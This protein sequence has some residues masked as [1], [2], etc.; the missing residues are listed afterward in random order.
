M[1]AGKTY[2][3]PR[4]QPNR[5]MRAESPPSDTAGPSRVCRPPNTAFRHR[6][7]SIRV[8]ADRH[9]P[10]ASTQTALTVDA[11]VKSIL[12][13][14]ESA[15]SVDESGK[16]PL[17]DTAEP[18]FVPAPATHRQQSGARWALSRSSPQRPICSR[19]KSYYP[20]AVPHFV[21]AGPRTLRR[22]RP[23]PQHPALRSLRQDVCAKLLTMC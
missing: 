22:R 1:G 17:A 8:S 18:V 4:N 21:A 14:T 3:H 20:A 9:P 19:R 10:G 2:F 13:S 16:T 5:W 6:R 7:P 11:T 23:A 12:A 15:Q